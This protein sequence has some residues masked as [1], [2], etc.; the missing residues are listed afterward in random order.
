M[1]ERSPHRNLPPQDQKIQKFL[2]NVR[3]PKSQKQVQRYIGFVNYYRNYIPRL[4]KKMLGF[5][6]LLKADKQVKVTEEL[7]DHYKAINAALTQAYGL[8]LKQ[9]ITRRQYVLMTDPRF[10]AS[11]YALM[12]EEDTDKNSTQKR[13]HLPQSNS[14]RTWFP[15]LN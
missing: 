2:A 4:S 7:L 5:F 1:E 9:P 11:N 3:F 6:E 10:R 15:Q 8:A 12:I 13:K 14:D